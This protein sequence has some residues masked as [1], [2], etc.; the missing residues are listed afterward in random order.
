LVNI[1]AF[2]CVSV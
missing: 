2:F 1:E